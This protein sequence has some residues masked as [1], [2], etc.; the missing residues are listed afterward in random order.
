[1]S[2]Y[3]KIETLYARDAATFKLQVPYVVKNPAYDLVTEWEWTE[4]IDGTNM[5]IIYTP[6]VPPG[7]NVGNDASLEFRG[8]TDNANIPGDLVAYMYKLVALDGMRNKF[9]VPVVIYGE[10]YGAGIQSGGSLSATKKFIAFDAKIDGKWLTRTELN[11]LCTSLGIEVVPYVGSMSLFNAMQMVSE[12]F[13]SKIGLHPPAEGL[14]GR[15]RVPLY[16]QFHNRMIVKLKT[17]D[18]AK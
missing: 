11:D 10:G 7:E 17:K 8:R 1:M 5:R 3:H 12:G 15:P 16:D 18:F 14:V 13:A 9:S 2:E 4:K 6:A